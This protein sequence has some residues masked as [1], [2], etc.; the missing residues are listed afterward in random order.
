MEKLTK[1]VKGATLIGDAKEVMSK[2]SMCG[3]DLE[4]APDFAVPLVVVSM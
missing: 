2:I 3:N 4:L 1:P